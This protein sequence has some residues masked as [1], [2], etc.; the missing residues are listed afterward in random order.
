MKGFSHSTGIV[1]AGLLLLTAL[2]VACGGTDAPR[3]SPE[4][5]VDATSDG[6]SPGISEAL[7]IPYREALFTQLLRERPS[8]RAW[9]RSTLGDPD[10]ATSRLV[11]NRHVPGAT[12]TLV[13]LYYPGIVVRFHVPEPGG[14]L[15]S[16]LDVSDNRYLA[17]PLI[18]APVALVEEEVGP[19]DEVGDTLRSYR[20]HSCVAGDDPVSMI[21]RDGEIVR[22]RFQYYV[23]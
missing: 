5:P 7:D 21:V 4:A 6:A 3:I 1:V 9:V 10:S 8:S 13:A 16:Q 19:A 22:I 23:D 18:G 14:E 17:Y 2:T 12:D 11:P 20:C 15:L